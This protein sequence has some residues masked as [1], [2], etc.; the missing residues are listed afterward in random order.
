MSRSLY[1]TFG[2]EE[3]FQIRKS[4]LVQYLKNSTIAFPLPEAA[5]EL[6]ANLEG[7]NKLSSSMNGNTYDVVRA[8]LE[9]SGFNAPIAKALAVSLITVAEKQGVDPLDYFNVNES[10]LKMVADAYDA[11]NETRPVGNLIGFS[12][13]LDNQSS[14]IRG[15]IK[16]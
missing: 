16:P 14:R 10:T 12:A 9:D 6:L 1:D 3:S 15:L 8:K 11:I 7:F 5:S 13:P 4:R 2:N